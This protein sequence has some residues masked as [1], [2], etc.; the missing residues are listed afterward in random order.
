MLLLA[1]VFCGWLAMNNI[2]PVAKESLRYAAIEEA[3][4]LLDAL[5]AADLPMPGVYEDNGTN[6]LSLVTN[7]GV[8]DVFPFDNASPL[9][10]GYRLEVA[11][12]SDAQAYG[13]AGRWARIRLFDNAEALAS[14]DQAFAEFRLFLGGKGAP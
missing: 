5:S 8:D 7:A 2:Q 1:V 10:I 14:S 9:S 12:A 3:A 4:G 11:D 6:G 13:L